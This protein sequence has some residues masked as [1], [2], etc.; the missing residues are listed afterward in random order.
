MIQVKEFTFNHFQTNCYVLWDEATRECAIVDPAA[1]ASYED[2]QVTQYIEEQHLT[3][4]YILLT[5]AHVDHV[6]GLRQACVRYGLPVTMHPDGTKLLR[7]CEAY[8]SV[9]GFDVRE[10]SDLEVRAIQDDDVLPL[11][12]GRIECRFVPGHC[13][14]SMCYVLPDE[15]VVLTGDALFRGSIGRTDLPGGDYNLLMEKLKSRVMTLDG[16][17]DVLPG[18]GECSTIREEQLGNPFIV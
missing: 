8:G 11:G 1:E 18:H 5:H 12:K 16:D 4:S 15:H 3:P 13:P 7:Q 6:A 14:G 10:M 17:Y 2:A 9:M